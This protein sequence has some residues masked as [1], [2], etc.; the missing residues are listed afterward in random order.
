MQ[1]LEIWYLRIAFAIL[2]VEAVLLGMR[3]IGG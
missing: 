3:S 2:L 1:R